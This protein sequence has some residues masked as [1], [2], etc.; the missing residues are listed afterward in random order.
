MDNLAEG[1]AAMGDWFERVRANDP[2]AVLY[3]NDY[4]ILSTGGATNTAKQQFYYDTL[5]AL[6]SSGAP[7]GGIGFQGHFN[8]SNLSGPE[9]VWDILDRFAAGSASTCRSPSSISARPTSNCRPSTRETSSPPCLP[10]RG[11]TTS[12]CGAS[13]K[14]PTG[15]PTQPCIRSDWSIKPNGEAYLDLVFDEWWTDASLASDAAGLAAL[16][17]FKGEY[18]ITVTL[19]GET[20]VVP[21]TL[22]DGGLELE[23]ALP[24]LAGDFDEDGDVDGR[25]FLVWQRNPSVGDLA[26]WQANYGV[27]SSAASVAVPEPS[28]IAHCLMLGALI[29]AVSEAD[30]LPPTLVCWLRWPRLS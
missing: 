18:L 13:G 8:E 25:D 16:R 3:L 23:I 19:N 2:T 29:L 28:V 4:N 7:L 1:N 5:A 27:S 10:T 9:Q 21:A 22:T 30:L 17:G 15:G 12:S 26:D 20:I 24:I 11:W 6:Q 14:T